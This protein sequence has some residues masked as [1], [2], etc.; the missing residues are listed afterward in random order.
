M[1]AD[2]IHELSKRS[3]ETLTVCF[4]VETLNSEHQ[5][6]SQPFDDLYFNSAGLA[7]EQQNIHVLFTF[8]LSICSKD[9]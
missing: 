2:Q 6:H 4:I 1:V 7:V 8:L 9:T 3:L 5:V